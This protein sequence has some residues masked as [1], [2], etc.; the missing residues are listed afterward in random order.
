[1]NFVQFQTKCFRYGIF[2]EEEGELVLLSDIDSNTAIT[3]GFVTFEEAIDT[4]NSV[5]K[6][7]PEP[8]ISIEEAEDK[9]QDYIEH[10]KGKK[11]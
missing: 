2:A 9:L 5:T 8:S 6:D 7:M 4:F 11:A 1:M 3:Q 10:I